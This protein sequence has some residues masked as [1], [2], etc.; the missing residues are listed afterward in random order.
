[1]KRKEN[2]CR[3]ACGP[4]WLVPWL[5]VTLLL[6]LKL[7]FIFYKSEGYVFVFQVI[8]S[9]LLGCH[10]RSMK[11]AHQTAFYANEVLWVGWLRLFTAR[12]LLNWQTGNKEIPLHK[13]AVSA[14][15]EW[16]GQYRTERWPGLLA[17]CRFVS[18]TQQQGDNMK[19]GGRT[20]AWMT[21]ARGRADTCLYLRSR[22][23]RGHYCFT[24]LLKTEQ[25]LRC[26]R[27][28]MCRCTCTER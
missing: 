2:R 10:L 3:I 17:T 18:N 6:S 21:R 5:F 26:N 9:I 27:T 1:M 28:Q 8:I 15:V 24:H 22:L 11:W 14:A 7:E 12:H 16:F 20:I 4:F 25:T 13:R 19:G 23:S